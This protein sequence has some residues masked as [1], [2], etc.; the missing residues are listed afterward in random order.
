[1]FFHIY[2]LYSASKSVHFS[3]G[4]LRSRR[5]S[6]N[7]YGSEV[8][9][10]GT[11]YNQNDKRIRNWNDDSNKYPFVSPSRYFQLEFSYF[12]LQYTSIS[13]E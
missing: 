4:G 5:R 10:D 3:T 9:D 1:M 12:F 2:S 7:R 13:N 6:I 11:R 8:N